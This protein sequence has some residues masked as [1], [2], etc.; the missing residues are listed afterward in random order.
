MN[1]PSIIIFTACSVV[2]T[3]YSQAPVFQWGA[4]VRSDNTGSINPVNA[5][6]HIETNARGDVFIS[7]AFPSNATD[8]KNF[9]FV[10]CNHYDAQGNLTVTPSPEGAG[11]TY[12]S[13]GFNNNFFLYK[14]NQAG[15]IVWQIVSDR[16]NADMHY[17]PITPTADGGVFVV[18]NICI[19]GKDDFD[20]SRLVRLIENGGAKKSL[21]RRNYETNTLQGVAAKI[22]ADGRVEWLKHIIRVDDA[23]IDGFNATTGTYFNDL[24]TDADGNYYLAGRY[25]K[26]L[27]FDTP[28]G[29]EQTLIPH[30]IT[31]WNGDPNYQRGDAL[32]VKLNPDGELL[33]SLETGGEV[34]YQSVNSLHCHNGALYLYG[35][36]AARPGDATS[37]SV[38]MGDTL[39]P[40][41]KTNAYSARLDVSGEQ[42]AAVWTTLFRALP[43]TNAYGGRIKVT[44][45]CYDNNALFLCGSFTG[46]AEANG[47]TILS[48]DRAE[49][50]SA[51]PLMAFII[52]QDL[53]TGAITGQVRDPA[54]G[55]A[56]EVVATAFRQN[57]IYAFGYNTG[58]SWIHIYDSDFR[59]TAGYN[60]FAAGGATAWDALFF[61]DR[62]VTLNRG[63][64]I[65]TSGGYIFGAPEAF[66]N[67]D[68][69]A[70]SAFFLA[71]ALDGLQETA[72]VRPAPPAEMPPIVALPGAIRISGNAQ[73]KIFPANGV[74]RYAGR[75]NGEERIVLP[76]GVYVVSVNGRTTK[77]AVKK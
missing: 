9:T 22:S 54:V 12:S 63:R 46:F 31:G 10:N 17:C 38:L 4:V 52:R 34:E 65:G 26:A 35:N 55:M 29:G 41:D 62:I 11:I 15:E 27:T 68:P 33:W 64:Y 44:N 40:T 50:E 19:S 47:D 7:G 28:G 6:V 45:L 14:M 18:L 57:R 1:L 5:A 36:V 73:V 58:A 8:A 77:V 66:V 24:A 60:L 51:S 67:D 21:Y 70:F 25:M 3:A 72:I 71:Y 32:L 76:A 53:A 2:L 56:A 16:G 42:P 20:D 74:R 48:N 39:R 23:P 37:Y 49:G 75:V 69:A 13:I 59:M 43:Q 30:N 61:N